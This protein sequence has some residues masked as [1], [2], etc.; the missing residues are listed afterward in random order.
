LLGG[1]GLIVQAAQS[2]YTGKKKVICVRKMPLGTVIPLDH[3]E[4]FDPQHPCFHPLVGGTHPLLFKTA[5]KFVEITSETL[6][7]EKCLSRLNL[8]CG[9]DSWRF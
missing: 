2:N 6:W 7:R 5:L 3:S 4:R 9:T 1:S 8:A